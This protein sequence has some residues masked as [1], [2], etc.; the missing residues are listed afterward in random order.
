MAILTI[1]SA[2]QGYRV[3]AAAIIQQAK[4]DAASKVSKK[5]CPTS[6]RTVSQKDKS[7]A[8]WFLSN[9]NGWY[10]DLKMFA[11]GFEN[12]TAQTEI[13]ASLQEVI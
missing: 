13:S 2:L 7:S 10:E 6:T 3:L 9:K 5:A 12:P 8:E 1:K 4:K 11:Q